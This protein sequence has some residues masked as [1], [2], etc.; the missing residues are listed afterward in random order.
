MATN[1]DGS[2]SVTTSTPLVCSVDPGDQLTV[3]YVGAGT[4]TL[5]PHTAAGID[6]LAA[7]GTAQSFSVAQATPAPPTI[8]NL[9]GGV[10]FGD[11]GFTASVTTASDGL[12]FVTSSTP[13]VCSVDPGD[14]L[15]V[16]YV[17][18]GTCTLNAH[19]P[20]TP[21]YLASDGED[22][23][24]SVAQATPNT[25]VIND[26]PVGATF[27]GSGFTA[28]LTTNSDGTPSVTSST[29]LV[30][31]V[32][33]VDQLTVTYTGAGTCT[34]TAHTAATSRH[35]AADGTPQ[36]F[37]VAQ[38]T[39]TAP[40][41]SDLPSGATF[42]GSFVAVVGTNGDGNT[43]VSSTDT[44]VCTV[45][46]DGLTVTYV[47]VGTCTLTAHVAAGTD[48]QAADGSAQSFSVAQANPNAPV[49]NDIPPAPPSAAAASPRP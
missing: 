17:G 13:L 40:T 9:P 6:Y 37:N 3:T 23:S 44:S 22:Q 16:T 14:R 5:T 30:C 8:S 31:T 15:T 27:G 25:P 34:L 35:M 42:G 36:S 39:P 38:A 4:C 2:P 19:T 28:T 43:L 49:I 29:P 41:I 24:F 47:G 48:Y 32:D 12:P 21:N 45:G 20:A 46:T 33:Q 11:S 10:T 18:V 7:D 26:T 1:S